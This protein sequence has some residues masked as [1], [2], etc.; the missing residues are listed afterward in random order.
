M[1]LVERGQGDTKV[2]MTHCVVRNLQIGATSH[3][4][5]TEPG[6]T[7]TV[8]DVLNHEASAGGSENGGRQSH[9][10]P[11]ESTEINDQVIASLH[12]TN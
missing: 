3:M 12:N 2:T 6:D 8:G 5:V 1:T 7:Q 9:E 4:V 10:A 11:L